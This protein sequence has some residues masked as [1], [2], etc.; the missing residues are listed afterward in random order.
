M[1]FYGLSSILFIAKCR[2]KIF[3]A[4]IPF[5]RYIFQLSLLA[6]H[7]GAFT[8]QTSCKTECVFGFCFVALK[9]TLCYL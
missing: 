7:Y 2:N 4:L 1:C 5:Y 9:F 8:L 3:K 6:M